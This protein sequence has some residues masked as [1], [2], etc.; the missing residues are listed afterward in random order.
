M[1]KAEE[2]KIQEVSPVSTL[3][4]E[5]VGVSAKAAPAI[6]KLMNSNRN[7]NIFISFLP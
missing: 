1:T 3:G 2:I 5:E 7:K 6:K 4:A